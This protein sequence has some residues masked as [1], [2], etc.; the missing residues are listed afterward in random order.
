M[1]GLGLLFEAD[2]YADLGGMLHDQRYRETTQR[3]YDLADR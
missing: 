1:I 2:A 3:Y